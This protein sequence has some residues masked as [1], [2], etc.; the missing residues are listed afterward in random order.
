MALRPTRGLNLERFETLF[1]VPVDSNVVSNLSDQK[2]AEQDG[3]QLRLTQ[4]G[5]LMADYIAS[6]LVPY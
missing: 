5:R 4:S 2:L 6:L 3:D 1:G